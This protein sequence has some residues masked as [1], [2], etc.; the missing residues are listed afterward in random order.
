LV[1]CLFVNWLLLRLMEKK[2]IFLKV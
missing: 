2:G 1:L